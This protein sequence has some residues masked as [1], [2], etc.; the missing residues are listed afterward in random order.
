MIEAD[1]KEKLLSLQH[2]MKNFARLIDGEVLKNQDLKALVKTI[3]DKLRLKR[4]STEDDSSDANLDE[5]LRRRK[6]LE[7]GLEQII[8]KNNESL[9]VIGQLKEQVNA[10]RSERVIYSSIFKNLEREIRVDEEAFKR[11]IIEKCQVELERAETL[12]YFQKQE[13]IRLK[14]FGHPPVLPEESESREEE[15]ANLKLHHS[16]RQELHRQAE[17]KLEPDRKSIIK[18]KSTD[19]L[20]DEFEFGKHYIRRL[21]TEIG[22]ESIDQVIEMAGTIEEHNSALFDSIN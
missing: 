19:K 11:L 7:Y 17:P 21:E 8:Q 6:R 13:D 16:L 20:N 5:L 9:A 1:C 10:A 14:Q 22:V 15:E 18:K 4:T 2:E 12:K 3:D